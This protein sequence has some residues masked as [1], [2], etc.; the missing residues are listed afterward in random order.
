MYK[1]KSIFYDNRWYKSKSQNLFEYK[2]I[3]NKKILINNSNL[4]DIKRVIKSSEKSFN[5]WRNVSLSNR[6]K[7][8]KGNFGF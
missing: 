3:K 2:N 5:L 8:L 1:N 6:S 4:K 7:Y